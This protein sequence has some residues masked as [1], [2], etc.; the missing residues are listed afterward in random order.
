MVDGMDLMS[1][2]A[3][4]LGFSLVFAGQDLHAMKR[5]NDKVFGSVQGNTNTKIIMRTEDPETAKLA[6]EAGGKALRAQ[7]SSYEGEV[8]ELSTSYRDKMDAQVQ[9]TDRINP[10][11]LKAQDEGEM[12]ILHKDWLVRAKTFYSAPQESLRKNDL[13]LRPNHFITVAKP[14][15]E[16][17]ESHRRIPELFARFLD[18]DFAD[19]MKADAANAAA[20]L[21]GTDEAATLARVMKEIETSKRRTNNPVEAAVAAFAK[22]LMDSKSMSDAYAK[23]VHDAVGM[24]Q[25]A[26]ADFDDDEDEMPPMRGRQRDAKGFPGLDSFDDGMDGFDEHPAAAARAAEPPKA[27]PARTPLRKNRFR[28]D[29]KHGVQVDG[30]ELFEMADRISSNDSVMRTLAALD[31]DAATEPRT[32][33]AIDDAIEEAIGGDAIPDFEEKQSF[34]RAAVKKA[35]DAT[36]AMMPDFEDEEDEDTGGGD[37]TTNFLGALIDDDEDEDGDGL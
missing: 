3:R 29:V 28:K 1:A 9:S 27:A 21:S 16:E 33:D 12:H 5:F 37:V 25:R 10:L 13:A 2:Q 35:D 31:F 24:R 19:R 14:D 22:V 36:L 23:E 4:S 6:V 8:G 18:R 7:L 26:L 17:I 11:D 20:D 15:A 30:N 34:D 32:R